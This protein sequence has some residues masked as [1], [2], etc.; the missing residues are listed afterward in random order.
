M[1][2]F[3]L[4]LVL[5]LGLSG[6]A[7]VETFE[8][9]G[10]VQ[11]EA[12]EAPAMGKILLD[13]PDSAAKETFSNGADTMYTCNGYDLVLQTFESGDLSKTV[14]AISGFS[15]DQLTVMASQTGDHKRYEWVWTA[16]GEGTDVLCRGAVLDD[17]HYHYCLYV[18]APADQAGRLQEEWGQIFNSFC[19]SSL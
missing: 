16:A 1:K 15:A 6:C 9:L 10:Q 17:G 14:E 7:S 4:I 2:K 19:I 8:T 13:I 11:H 12:Q 18:M 5:C 3:C